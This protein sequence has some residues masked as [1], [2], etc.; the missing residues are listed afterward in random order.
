MRVVSGDVSERVSSDQKVR[1][2]EHAVLL[3]RESEGSSRS[4]ITQAASLRRGICTTTTREGETTAGLPSGIH[5]SE[6]ERGRENGISG[7]ERAASSLSFRSKLATQT[8]DCRLVRLS[9]CIPDARVDDMPQ[10]TECIRAD[11]EE[12]RGAGC[13]RMHSSASR[14]GENVGAS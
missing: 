12:S 1:E 6:R 8:V 5:G 2:R 14:E 11:E 3:P 7:A 9:L 4:A 13:A 10:E